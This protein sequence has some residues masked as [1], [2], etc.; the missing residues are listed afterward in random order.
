MTKLFNYLKR[1]FTHIYLIAI[2]AMCGGQTIYASP[3]PKEMLVINSYNENAP[4]VQDYITPFM[5]KAAQTDGLNCNMVHMNSTQIR[6]DSLYD[7]V[8][9]GIFERFKDNHP[10][11]LVLIG[12]MAFSLCD[13][14]KAEWG[15]IPMLLMGTNDKIGENEKFLTGDVSSLNAKLSSLSDIRSQYNFT[16]IE[17]P[18]MYKETIDMMV[19]M[20]P[21]MKKLVF[22]SDELV[23]N[24]ELDRK[25]RDYLATTYPQ[26]EYERLVAS[27]TSRKDMRKYLMSKDLS[28]GVL[29]SSWYY[30]RPSAFGY[31]MLVT[32]DFNLLSASPHPIF[33]LKENYID[34]GAIGGC[35]IDRKTILNLCLS[36]LQTMLTSGNMRNLPFVYSTKAV[37]K[38]NYERLK[39]CHIPESSCPE[40]TV[41]IGK[42]ESLWELYSWQIVLGGALLAAIM[43]ILCFLTIFQRKRMS[44]MASRNKMLDNMP[45]AYMTGRIK[46]DKDGKVTDINFTSGNRKLD[47]LVRRNTDDGDINHLFDMTY[48]LKEIGSLSENKEGGFVKFTYFFEKTGVYYDFRICQTLSDNEVKFFGVDVTSLIAAKEAAKESDRLKSA[49]LAN[50]SHEIRTPLN[51]IIGFSNLLA[52]TDA[53]EDRSRFIDIIEKNNEQLLQLINDILDLSKVESNTLEF[54][55]KPTDLNSLMHD[56]EMSV[57][58]KV[59]EGVVLNCVTGMEKCHISTPPTRL[60]QV[61]TNLITNACKFTSKGSIL[62]GYEMQGADT[63]FF[64]VRDTGCGISKE[65]QKRVFQRFVKLNEFAQGTGLGLPI[66]QNIVQKMG[67]EIGVTSDGEGKGSMFWFTIP[68][69]PVEP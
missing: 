57:H 46:S 11:Y 38:I 15:D 64:Y 58:S 48:I 25:I 52:T 69:I 63:L 66:C 40:G 65:G 62:F 67:G 55:Y 33:T 34:E 10:D 20:Q 12:K 30:S 1:F 37:C 5:L 6:T 56:I 2:L 27:E 47:S 21:E 51:A 39:D 42:P 14:I 36:V 50:M 61:I 45:V 9:N 44:Y 3:Q 35:F 24:M 68:Y 23:V 29:L 13:R 54:N 17:I 60:T 53:P 8:E 4:W 18:D 43:S 49:F 22:A 31:P 41:F 28:V 7:Q 32:G 19:Q 16:Y 26:M 59:P